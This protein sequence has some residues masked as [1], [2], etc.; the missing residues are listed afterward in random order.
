[1]ST[2]LNMK[3]KLRLADVAER[4]GV[5]TA[6]VDRVIHNRPGV[7]PHTVN[8]IQAVI[9]KMKSGDNSEVISGR[10]QGLL[11]FDVILP[12]GS[13]SFFNTLE[14]QIRAVSQTFR[15]TASFNIRRVEG[16]DP[17]MLAQSIHQCSG[18]SDGIALVAIEDPLVRDAVSTAVEAGVPVVQINT[19][20]FG[21]DCH[22]W[23]MLVRTPESG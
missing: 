20:E 16:F 2:T 14:S 13:N 8:H 17:R 1:L 5:S 23:V 18:T 7:K 22:C 6:T 11:N 4:A 3:N 15:G 19:D 10:S 21:G 9:E 12:E